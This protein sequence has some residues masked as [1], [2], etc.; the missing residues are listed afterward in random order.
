MKQ[1][2]TELVI[3]FANYKSN[4]NNVKHNRLHL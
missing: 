4:H 3:Y 2:Y 1:L